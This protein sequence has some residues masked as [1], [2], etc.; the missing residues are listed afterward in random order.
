MIPRSQEAIVN[1]WKGPSASAAAGSRIE[2]LREEQGV[3]GGWPSRI[4]AARAG[5]EWPDMPY[6]RTLSEKATASSPTSSVQPQ[7][8]RGKGGEQARSSSAGT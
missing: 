1:P 5:Y 6:I 4:R 2:I 3:S 8:E 7:T